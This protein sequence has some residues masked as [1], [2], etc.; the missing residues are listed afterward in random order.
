MQVHNYFFFNA[1]FL[2]MQQLFAIAYALLVVLILLE[3]WHD[4]PLIK[5]SV[6]PR[7]DYNVLSDIMK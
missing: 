3:L 6:E 7:Y 1:V 2:S 5:S 4:V